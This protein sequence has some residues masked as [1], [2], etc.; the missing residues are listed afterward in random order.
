MPSIL[1][2]LTRE[3]RTASMRAR[4]VEGEGSP[5]TGEI[6]VTPLLI[7]IEGQEYTPL[8]DLHGIVVETLDEVEEHLLADAG[9]ALSMLQ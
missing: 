4:I 9:F 2:D 1:D 7:V 5:W 3:G 8:D 6:V